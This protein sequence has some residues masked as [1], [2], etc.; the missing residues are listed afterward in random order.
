MTVL[1]SSVPGSDDGHPPPKPPRRVSVRAAVSAGILIAIPVVALLL[2]PTYASRGPEL[3]GFPF[4]YWY[5]L[6]WIFIAAGCTAG[7]YTVLA[8]ARRNRSDGDR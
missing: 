4:F 6:L 2:V 1:P 7:A 3:W 5:Q 8:R